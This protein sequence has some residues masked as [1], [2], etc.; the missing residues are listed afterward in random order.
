MASPAPKMKGALTERDLE[1]MA[2]AWHCMKA[3]PEVDFAKL[4]EL[5]GMTNPRSAGNAWRNIKT[6]LFADLPPAEP[7]TPGP[8]RK[9]KTPAKSR[10]KATPKAA[11][12]PAS[13]DE[14]NKL[15]AT[16]DSDVDELEAQ[17]PTKKRKSPAKKAG[18]KAPLSAAKVEDDSDE[19]GEIKT[20]PIKA[21]EQE[22]YIEEDV[23]EI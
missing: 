9:R 19:D 1:I 6:K 12:A 4:A 7:A 5:T 2:K 8:G 20:E 21:E 11:A 17:S 15:I 14:D 23:G 13:D 16:A 18:K 3:E 10:A 22:E